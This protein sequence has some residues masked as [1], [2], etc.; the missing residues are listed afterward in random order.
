MSKGRRVLMAAI[1][2][3]VWLSLT[4]G[5]TRLHLGHPLHRDTFL[6]LAPLTPLFFMWRY[7]RAGKQSKKTKK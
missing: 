5:A 2:T 3:V 4:L 6:A 1:H 7:W